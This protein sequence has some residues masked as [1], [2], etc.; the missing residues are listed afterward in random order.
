MR[1]VFMG[2]PEFG[3]PTL[4]RLAHSEHQ[5]VA[6]YTQP[7]RPAGRGRLLTPSP[8]KKTALA[9]GLAVLQPAS[10]KAPDEVE[11]L[12]GS[13]PDVIVVAAFGQ[14]LPRSVLDIPPF[15][16]L[17]IHPSLLPKHRGSAP[18]PAAI[19]S[20]DEETGVTIMLMDPG[21]DTGPVLA[22]KA[23]PLEAQDTAQSLSA[24]LAELGAELL[25]QTLSPWL[26]H[27]LSPQSQDEENATYSHPISKGE[28]EIDWHLPAIELWRLVRAFYPW[29][30]CYTQ[31]RGRQL[32][33]L[34]TIPLSG[35]RGLKPGRVI[36]LSPEAGAVVGVVTGGGVLGLC[37][38][39]LEGKRAM[40][41]ADF[42]RGHGEF[43]GELIPS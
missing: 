19:L 35:G 14:L 13:K 7:G 1:V 21:L 39:Q 15:G 40:V 5:I 27:R 20:G 18:I 24:K 22:Q 31:W 8:V 6:V 2:T 34:E 16:C 28:G 17:N 4:E 38:L 26:D 23:I 32:K 25:T 11:R 10:L 43:I 3:V 29:P 42:L 41:A 9:Y 12:R 36:S 33:L 30:G 37:R